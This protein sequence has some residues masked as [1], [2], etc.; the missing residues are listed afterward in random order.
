MPTMPRT[1]EYE[2]AQRI[3]MGHPAMAPHSHTGKIVNGIRRM[4]EEY[5]TLAER[6]IKGRPLLECP[7]VRIS[8]NVRLWYL[9][10]D[11]DGFD[12]FSGRFHSAG[13]VLAPDTNGRV[14]YMAWGE[15]EVE[16]LFHGVAFFDGVRHLFVGEGVE[17][18]YTNY[19][20]LQDF[21]AVL[22]ALAA[23]E[24]ELCWYVR[25]ER[26]NR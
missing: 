15:T 7:F 18:G 13:Y 24:I 23:L 5:P 10:N 1:I 3:A 21:A 2:H 14:D 11:L 25:E 6:E 22:F 8:E 12:F 9:P 19:P 26:N 4:G 17:A 20:Y 16:P